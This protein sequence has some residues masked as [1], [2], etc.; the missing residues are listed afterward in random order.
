MVSQ[1]AKDLDC[2]EFWVNDKVKAKSSAVESGQLSGK[3]TEASSSKPD[4][5]VGST[6]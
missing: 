2:K 3:S 1:Q 4:D 5:S 6:S